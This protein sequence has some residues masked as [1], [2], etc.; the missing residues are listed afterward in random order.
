MKRL[1]SIVILT[2]SMWT[3]AET[4]SAQVTAAD[5]FVNAPVE[6]FPLVDRNTRLDMID[7]FRS[8]STT[9]SNNRLSGK[10]RV[11]ELGNDNIALDMTE[12]SSYQL[13]LLPMGSDTIIA[14]I[15]TVK[16]PSRDSQLT[17][18]TSKWKEI[19]RKLFEKP[20]L[21]DWLTKKGEK[22]R[23]DAEAVI[24]FVMS[25]Y[26]YD[27][28]TKELRATNSM[29]QFYS[30]DEYNAVKPYMKMVLTYRWN[31]KKMKPVK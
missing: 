15:K 8:G 5:V 23:K 17:F 11:T 2:V 21:S 14:L 25:E 26:K 30:E 16:T 24:P 19:D 27:A 12:A 9:S 13:A 20:V 22:N 6:I 31:G 10:A 4:M 1:L 7:Y 3:V 18:Y 28:E 29:R